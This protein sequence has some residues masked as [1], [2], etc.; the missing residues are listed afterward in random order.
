MPPPATTTTTKTK[1]AFVARPRE[2]IDE[3]VIPSGEW[4][5]NWSLA[6][7]EDVGEYYAGQILKE[8]QGNMVS[9]IMTTNIVTSGPTDTV[10]VRT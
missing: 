2:Q 10:Q 9:S 5:A 1:P 7:Y 3:D 4:P 6:S 8:E